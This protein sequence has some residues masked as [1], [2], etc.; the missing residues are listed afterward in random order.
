MDKQ[1]RLLDYFHTHRQKLNSQI[2]WT[3]FMFLSLSVTWNLLFKWLDVP[4][5]RAN[6]YIIGT[7]L[8]IS[9]MLLLIN[10]YTQREIMDHLV[11]LYTLLIFV[12]LY[13]G[14]GF[15]E[16][17]AYF[18]ITPI[19]AGLYGS[20]KLLLLYS[21]ISFI[22]LT[23]VSINYPLLIGIDSIDISNQLLTH[24]IVTTFSYMV[25]RKLQNLYRKQI[26]T[27]E[28]SAE[29]TIEQVVRSFIVSV[30][31]KDVY[32]FGHSER[33]SKYAVELAKRLPEYQGQEKKLHTIHLMG[34]LHDIGKINI[35][36]TVLCKPSRLTEEEFDL[37]KTH[38]VIG[39]RM[40]EK[41]TGLGHL[42]PGV[43][44]HHERWDG[45]GY[46]TQAEGEDIP[47]EARILSLADAFDAMTSSRAYRTSLPAQEAFQRLLDEKGTQF[48]PNLVAHLE[49]VRLVWFR[50]CKESQDDLEEFER[51]MDLF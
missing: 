7:L 21:L 43:L 49:S 42:K 40:I 48:D 44:Y 19:I 34:L 39:A 51:M 16:A 50:I 5:S 46:P 45:K 20:S 37:I 14:S 15:T 35:P 17:W 22:A 12:G 13:F 33:V 10:R 2:L 26:Q 47:L 4:Y 23:V 24:I 25:I 29:T 6:V 27:I 32:T 30:E 11:I 36:E 31:A 41:V 8:V 28:E 9:A 3:C 18:L 38:P 1:Q